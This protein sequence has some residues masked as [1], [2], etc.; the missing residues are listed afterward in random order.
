MFDS[1]HCE[2]K[3]GRSPPKRVD[4]RIESAVKT[5][6]IEF[7]DDSQS[8]FR[9]VKN[10]H[11]IPI[12]R[13]VD[14]ADSRSFN[15]IHWSLLKKI[16]FFSLSLLA[17]LHPPDMKIDQKQV[18]RLAAILQADSMRKAGLEPSQNTGKSLEHPG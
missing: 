15:P 10:N 18:Q 17:V 7:S 4:K 8:F 9:K 13:S 1:A 16:N 6:E 14:K 2:L 11:F 3:I 12:D 5:T